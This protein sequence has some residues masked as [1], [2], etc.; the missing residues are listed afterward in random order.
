MVISMLKCKH[1]SKK[2]NEYDLEKNACARDHWNYIKL[3]E[4]DDRL[5]KGVNLIPDIPNDSCACGAGWQD[6]QRP[7]GITSK[8]KRT[9]VVYTSYAPV[10][11]DVYVRSCLNSQN[12]CTHL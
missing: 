4:I 10:K 12:L 2:Q 6:E 7:N 5:L 8:N 1:S 11:Y 9:L 3:K